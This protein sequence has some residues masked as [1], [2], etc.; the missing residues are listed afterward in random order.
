[1]QGVHVFD[2]GFIFQ[3]TI[4]KDVA[5]TMAMAKRKILWIARTEKLEAGFHEFFT[6]QLAAREILEYVFAMFGEEA[7]PF[8]DSGAISIFKLQPPIRL[9][10]G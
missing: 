2:D 3:Y 5:F 6:G 8:L 4:V 9:E 1:M 7:L 10:P